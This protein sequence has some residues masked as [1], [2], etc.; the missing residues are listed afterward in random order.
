MQRHS[1]ETHQLTG[2]M[3]KK[4]GEQYCKP[5]WGPEKWGF[6]CFVYQPR[7]KNRDKNP[8][9]FSLYLPVKQDS[10]E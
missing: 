8:K 5:G 4:P 2:K 3:Q 1:D 7:I 6:R 10:Y 9:A